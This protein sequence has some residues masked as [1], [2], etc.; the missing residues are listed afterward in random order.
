VNPPSNYATL[1]TRVPVVDALN[2]FDVPSSLDTLADED[3][4]VGTV[5]DGDNPAGMD[6]NTGSATAAVAEPEAA[7]SVNGD[8]AA[9]GGEEDGRGAGEED[10]VKLD[11]LVVKHTHTATASK[12]SY[13]LVS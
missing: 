3:D 9:S 10:E 5:A 13:E 2:I 11:Q 12:S 8:G 7:P 1:D 4:S 6:G